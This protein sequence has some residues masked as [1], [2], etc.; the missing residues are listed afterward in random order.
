MRIGILVEKRY[1]S[2]A[3]PGGLIAA[4]RAAGHETICLDPEASAY[5]LEDS[6]WTENLDL[7]VARGRSLHLL[8]LLGWAEARGVRV[9]NRRSAIASVHNKADMAVLLAGARLPTP[10]TF[11]GPV[12][13][14]YKTI[15]SSAYPIILKPI[16][17]DNSR[18]LRLV[19]SPEEMKLVEWPEPV[20][21]AQH[22]IVNDGHDLKLY[23]IG[24]EICAVRKPSPFGLAVNEGVGGGKSRAAKVELVPLTTGLEDLGRSLRRLFGLELYGVDC[25]ETPEGPVVIEVN[26][27]PNYTGVP[28]ADRRLADYVTRAGGEKAH[29]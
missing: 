18:G 16:F 7:I 3:Q 25:I 14:L 28:D 6:R 21:L 17:G 29:I 5:A 22:F 19:H 13:E 2:Q 10:Q 27:F 12:Q 8:C 4:L 11:L 23:G 24:D 20:A 26:E 1:L 15:P 9:I